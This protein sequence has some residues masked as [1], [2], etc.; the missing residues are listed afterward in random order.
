MEDYEDALESLRAL[1]KHFQW[2]LAGLIHYYDPEFTNMISEFDQKDNVDI[3]LE[4]QEK[5]SYNGKHLAE[6]IATSQSNVTLT[7]DQGYAA[8]CYMQTAIERGEAAQITGKQIV[9]CCGETIFEMEEFVPSAFQGVLSLFRRPRQLPGFQDFLLGFG[10]SGLE[11]TTFNHFYNTMCQSCTSNPT[12]FKPCRNF[13]TSMKINPSTGSFNVKKLVDCPGG[14]IDICSECVTSLASLDTI[15]SMNFLIKTIAMETEDIP[16]S[17]QSALAQ[18]SSSFDHLKYLKLW[19]NK[20]SETLP[21]NKNPFDV[22]YWNITADG[23]MVLLKVD[24]DLGTGISRSY[25]P[26]DRSIQL[27]NGRVVTMLPS[28]C[29]QSCQP[30]EKKKLSNNLPQVCCYKCEICEPGTYSNGSAFEECWS[31]PMDEWSHKGEQSCWKK[32]HGGSVHVT[33]KSDR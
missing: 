4:F 21:I 28:H 29:L 13:Q 5:A 18:N 12:S 27:S 9:S 25:D 16:K 33:G 23:E 31:C 24:I 22:Y 1:M 2:N 32:S 10:T 11:N 8:I 7:I 15:F 19:K 30:G 20:H 26:V 14:S 3:C 17:Q 6:R